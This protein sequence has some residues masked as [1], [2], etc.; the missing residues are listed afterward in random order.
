MRITKGSLLKELAAYRLLPG[1]VFAQH[2]GD[3]GARGILKDHG[4]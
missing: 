1:T 2:D 4:K 3:I